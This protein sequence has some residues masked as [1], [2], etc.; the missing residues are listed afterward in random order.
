MTDQIH[1]RGLTAPLDPLKRDEFSFH[2]PFGILCT[3][4]SI[5]KTPENF[6][7]NGSEARRRKEV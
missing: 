2:N 3:M 7:G 5:S 1:L 6:K 4:G